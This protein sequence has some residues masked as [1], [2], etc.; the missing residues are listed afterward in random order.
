MKKVSSLE[1]CF[2]LLLKSKWSTSHIAH[3]S[4]VLKTLHLGVFFRA[5]IGHSSEHIFSGFKQYIWEAV[6]N[7]NEFWRSTNICRFFVVIVFIQIFHPFKYDYW[8]MKETL[9]MNQRV[10]ILWQMNESLKLFLKWVNSF[11][12]ID[13][14]N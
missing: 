6:I 10:L 1:G 5:G 13:Y 11:S 2:F 7:I 8:F 9:F 4:S 12:K 3:S 14:L